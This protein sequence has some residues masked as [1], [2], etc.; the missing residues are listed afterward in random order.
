[1]S[2]QNSK[3]INLILNG[4]IPYALYKLALPNIFAVF[5]YSIV[6][7][8]E[9]WYIS[10]VSIDELASL[11]LVFPFVSLIGMIGLGAIGG[12]ITSCLSKAIGK[13]DKELA[14]K[15]LWHSVLIMT[16]LSFFFLLFFVF[17]SSIIFHLIGAE[18]IVENR[19]V[20]FMQ[21]F[22]SF[23]PVMFFSYLFISVFR[24]CGSYQALA[25]ITI[26]ANISQ[27]LLSGVLTLGLWFFPQLGLIGIAI[28]TIICQGI[29]A[30]YMFLYIIRGNFNISFKIYSFDKNI[31]IDILRVGGISSINAISITLTML[32]VTFFVSGYGTAAIAGYGICLRLE[33]MLIPLAFGI[34]GVL[35]TIVG[36][37]FGAENFKRAKKAAWLGASIIGFIATGIGS[38]VAF[39]PDIWINIF[40]HDNDA[41]S[42]AS[43]YLVIVG[44]VFGIFALGKTLYFASMGTGNMLIPISAGLTRLLIVFLFGMLATYF[45]LDIIFLFFGVSLGLSTIGII[46]IINMFKKAWNPLLIIK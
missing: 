31:I 37:N 16:F 17:L 6:T 38:M 41:F 40:T 1:M 4:P 20:T 34:G 11:A 27:V 8:S 45:S 36:M 46:L 18:K 21:V 2:L 23:A 43:K 32:L 26:L 5:M 22:F 24:G 9:A 10:R 25:R 29:A 28:S 13:N 39:F 12:G 3:N 33:Q 30:I 15:I 14:N 44:P 42:I 19:S 7:F 35:T